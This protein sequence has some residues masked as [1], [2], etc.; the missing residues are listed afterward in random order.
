MPRSID[1]PWEAFPFLKRKGGEVDGVGAHKELRGEEARK[2][3]LG[4]KV[5]KYID[6]IPL[7]YWKDSSKVKNLQRTKNWFPHPHNGSQ[8]SSMD[9]R[10]SS[11]IHWHQTFMWFIHEFKSLIHIKLINL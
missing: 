10:P 8:S 1:I 11:D 5:K 9:L 7:W 4:Y 6:K 2:I 3:H